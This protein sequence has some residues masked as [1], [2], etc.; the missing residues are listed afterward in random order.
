MPKV[1]PSIH[2][3][4]C[5]SFLARVGDLD[6]INILVSG[7]DAALTGQSRIEGW[8][9]VKELRKTQQGSVIIVA[10]VVFDRTFC[11][12]SSSNS[13]SANGASSLPTSDGRWFWTLP[14]EY[15]ALKIDSKELVAAAQIDISLGRH[16]D[17]AILDKSLLMLIG[18]NNA[19]RAGAKSLTLYACLHDDV[20]FYYLLDYIEG[21]DLQSLCAHSIQSASMESSSSLLPATETKRPFPLRVSETRLRKIFRNVFSTL[22]F[23]HEEGF[24]HRDVSPE[25]ILIDADGSGVLIDFG[26]AVQITRRRKPVDVDRYFSEAVNSASTMFGADKEEEEEEEKEDN[27]DT[28]MEGTLD[29]WLPQSPPSGS[30]FCKLSYAD[31]QYVWRMPWYG[32][33]GDLYSC[34]I[35]MFSAIEGSPLYAAPSALDSRFAL[36]LPRKSSDVSSR[37]ERVSSSEPRFRE[38]MTKRYGGSV[39]EEYIELVASLV[40]IPPEERPLSASAVLKHRW[41]SE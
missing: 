2:F 29:G 18:G 3:S 6:G 10:K 23:L 41:F 28:I 11:S 9:Y 34:G 32:V 26:A 40:R 12:I 39:S 30:P 8:A 1:L 21:G 22:S 38:W 4:S 35:T 13:S 15:R 36:L 33:A 19:T 17:N 7:L 31:P 20:F 16:R 25:N 37:G 27:D 14:Y 24:A 5:R